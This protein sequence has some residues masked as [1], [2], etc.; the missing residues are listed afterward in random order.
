MKKC[1][2]T[3]KPCE[4][5]T[6]FHI[7]DLSD[8]KVVSSASCCED[9]FKEYLASKKEEIVPSEFEETTFSNSEDVVQSLLELMSGPLFAP[10]S[11]SKVGSKKGTKKPSKGMCPGCGSTLS[12]IAK[13]SKVGCAQCYDVFAR[14][15]TNVLHKAHG[16]TEHVGK[17]P[18]RIKEIKLTVTSLLEQISEKEGL[19]AKAITSEKYEDAAV[20]RDELKTLNAQKEKAEEQVAG[21]RKQ[22]TDAVRE[23]KFEK[24]AKIKQELQDLLGE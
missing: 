2:L 15:L 23:E 8:G 24:A 14:Q 11:I 22:L 18:K 13:S 1:P 19:M 16:S 10:Q 17:R 9:C 20:I 21:L 4:K 12:D 6:L 3:G 5:V 7:T